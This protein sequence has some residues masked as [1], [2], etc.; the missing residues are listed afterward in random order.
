MWPQTCYVTEN[1]LGI[2]IPLPLFLSL[3]PQCWVTGI[4][5]HA[6]PYVKLGVEPKTIC[7]LGKQSAS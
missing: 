7:M 1:D 4:H 5:S 3:D 6:Q 2:L